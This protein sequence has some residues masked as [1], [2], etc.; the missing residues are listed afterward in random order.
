MASQAFA[1]GLRR[2]HFEKSAS[3]EVAGET[4]PAQVVQ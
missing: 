1:L 2:W 3:A 4:E